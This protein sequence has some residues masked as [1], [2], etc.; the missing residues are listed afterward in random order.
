MVQQTA[1]NGLDA[2]IPGVVTAYTAASKI[3]GISTQTFVSLGGAMATYTG[4]NYGAGKY[5][6]IRKG[7]LVGM[8]YSAI[9]VGIGFLINVGLCEPLMRLFL[10]TDLSANVA[11]HYEEVLG[12]GRQYLLWQ[13]SFYIFLGAIYVF[14]N[15]LQGIGRSFVTT[16]AGVTELAGRVVASLFFVKLWGY[17]GIC[18]SN[19][20][21]WVAAVVFLVTTYCICIR[22]ALKAER[23]QEQPRRLRVRRALVGRKAH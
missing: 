20:V 18:M 7:V 22:K 10:N 8:I 15:T 16:F 5:D 9:S 3:D 12:Y 13:S 21:A 1:L 4:Q 17:T 6:R 11:A 2:A 19:S 23:T 14:R